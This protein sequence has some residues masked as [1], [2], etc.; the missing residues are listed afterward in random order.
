[1]I[2]KED[3]QATEM[4]ESVDS[5]NQQMAT[6]EGNQVIQFDFSTEKRQETEGNK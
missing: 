2:S 4:S 6:E 5:S 3:T 1:M